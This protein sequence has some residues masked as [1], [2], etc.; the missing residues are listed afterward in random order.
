VLNGVAL[1]GVQAAKLV[2]H[3]DAG[4]TAQV[5]EVFTLHAQLARQRIDSYFLFLQKHYSSADSSSQPRSEE[6]EC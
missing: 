5:E 4:L 1:L 2:F 3:V 6:R